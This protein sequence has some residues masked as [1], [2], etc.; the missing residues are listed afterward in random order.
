MDLSILADLSELKEEGEWD[1]WYQSNVIDASCACPDNT[2]NH[3]QLQ[4]VRESIPGAE[5]CD[6]TMHAMYDNTARS[7]SGGASTCGEGI[8]PVD[9]PIA[10]G[11]KPVIIILVVAAVVVG[12]FCSV[13]VTIKCKKCCC[14]KKGSSSSAAQKDKRPQERRDI[15]NPPIPTAEAQPLPQAPP[16]GYGYGNYFTKYTLSF[17]RLI[18]LQTIVIDCLWLQV[19]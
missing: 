19:V 3:A 1:S 9:G 10:C 5:M 18:D 2:L 13:Y 17:R 4:A 7:H 16:P 11:L 8:E 12:C 6:T 14:D 15:I